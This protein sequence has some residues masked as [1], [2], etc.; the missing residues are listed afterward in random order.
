MKKIINL[1]L[2]CL[3]VLGACKKE[4]TKPTTDNSNT[5]TTFNCRYDTVYSSSLGTEIYEYDAQERISNI[6]RILNGKETVD[7]YT[8][9]GNQVEVKNDN[10]TSIFKLNSNGYA[11]TVIM[12]F[13]GVGSLIIYYFYN[14]QNQITKQIQEMEFG[15]NEITLEV[16]NYYLNGNNTTSRLLLNGEESIVKNEYHLDRPNIFKEMEYKTQFI[17]SSVNLIKASI[18]D[19]K[20]NQQFEYQF[21]NQNR[22]VFRK[23]INPDGDEQTESFVWKCK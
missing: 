3:L 23:V 10:Q 16:E 8:Y 5:G 14:S 18:L 12:D 1:S 6:T 9:M 7:T 13:R 15:G 22:V 20:P 17:P 2:L 19:D 4:S 11:D 21:D